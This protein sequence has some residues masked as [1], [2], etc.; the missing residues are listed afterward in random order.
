MESLRKCRCIYLTHTS[1]PVRHIS[2]HWGRSI[3]KCIEKCIWIQISLKIVLHGSF[4]IKH[5]WFIQWPG[6]EQATSYFLNRW[7]PSLLTHIWVNPSCGVGEIFRGE[8]AQGHCRGCWCPGSW[9]RKVI[10]SHDSDLLGQT[11]R[12]LPWGRIYTTCGI[13]I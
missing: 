7:W 1:T 10:S 13:L 3:F 12:C 6:A 8:R 9:G 4:C 5:H 11:Y 2:T